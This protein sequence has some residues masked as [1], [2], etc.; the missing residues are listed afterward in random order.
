[1]SV[2]EKL[3]AMELLWDDLCN[4][5]GGVTSPAWHEDVL[6]ER[7]A[8]LGRGE[9]RFEDWEAAKRDIKNKVS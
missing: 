8:M 4:K 9:D 6:A 7:D 1:M 5:A 2:E 3:R